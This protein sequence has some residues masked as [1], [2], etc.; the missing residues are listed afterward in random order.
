MLE[1]IALIHTEVP[2]LFAVFVAVLGACIGSFLN[3]VIYRLPAGLS[4]IRPGS[5]CACG[6]PIAWHDN[7][8]IL[9]WLLLRGQARC[10]GRRISVRYPLV[11]ALTSALFVGCWLRYSPA[12]A[13]CLM[14]FATF[15]VAQAFI[16][17]D[18]MEIPDRFSIGGFALGL[19]LAAA[20][21]AL[22]LAEAQRSGIPFLDSLGA[23]VVAL[24]GGLIG[25]SLI[26][27]I[28]ILAEVLLKK[29]AMGFG[30]VKLMGAI[31]AFCGWQG[32][33]FA[34]FG[35]AL[36]GS[37]AVF[38]LFIVQRFR[39]TAASPVPPTPNDPAAGVAGAEEGHRI[40][41]G[42]ALAGGAVLYL[43]LL[44]GPVD[45]YFSGLAEI[46]LPR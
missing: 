28:A 46:L 34:I 10:C 29:E 24:K 44:R 4:V 32:A 27:W 14:L 35:G 30:D 40:P 15:M 37:V 26:L 3:V 38:A 12:V 16:D 43:L 45:A 31:G 19:V 17:L 5:R 22:H 6:Q 36:L 33:V 11:E 42:P 25:S 41:F 1:D 21:P 23:F 2:W 9:G 18:T 13:L 8:P 20:V 7:V 39:P